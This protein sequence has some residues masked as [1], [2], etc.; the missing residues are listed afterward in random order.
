MKE[1][2]NWAL[3]I[4][5]LLFFANTILSVYLV[6]AG[7]ESIELIRIYLIFAPVYILGAAFCTIGS[8][9]FTKEVKII[10]K[11]MDKR[12]KLNNK[13]AEM[14]ADYFHNESDKPDFDG[15]IGNHYL[16]EEV[17]KIYKKKYSKER[18]W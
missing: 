13:E 9:V 11:Q 4:I 10:N 17:M 15:Y 2:I 5:G 16:P 18:E 14:F 12:R 1:K 7:Y 6:V 8:V 3:M